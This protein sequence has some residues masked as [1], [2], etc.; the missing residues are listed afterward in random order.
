MKQ[1]IEQ[2]PPISQCLAI[3]AHSLASWPNPNK[4]LSCLVSKFA[5]LAD[6][7]RQLAKSVLLIMLL[8]I[9]GWLTNNLL[10]ILFEGVPMSPITRMRVENSTAYLLYLVLALQAP[11]L[12]WLRLWP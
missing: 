12:L 2:K 1:A 6:T 3:S 9:L 4:S 8:E 7:G 5:E 11:L 10:R